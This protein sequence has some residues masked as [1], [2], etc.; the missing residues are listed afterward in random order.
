MLQHGRLHSAT[1]GM[2]GLEPDTEARGS[3]RWRVMPTT[4]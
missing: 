2:R 4:P 1:Q 3:M